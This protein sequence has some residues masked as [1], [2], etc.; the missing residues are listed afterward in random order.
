MLKYANFLIKLSPFEAIY[1]PS[2]PQFVYDSVNKHK[3]V[4]SQYVSPTK[5]GKIKCLDIN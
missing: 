4:H 5:D 2:Y 3:R 1:A